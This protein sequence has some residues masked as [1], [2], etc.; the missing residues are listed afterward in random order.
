MNYPMN[1]KQTKKTR[2][3]ARAGLGTINNGLDWIDGQQI[4]FGSTQFADHLLFGGS[5]HMQQEFT[6]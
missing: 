1:N 3:C 2:D 5:C 4:H 6:R